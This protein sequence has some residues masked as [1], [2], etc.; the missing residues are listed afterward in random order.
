M[1]FFAGSSGESEVE[2]YT[3]RGYGSTMDSNQGYS[4]NDRLMNVSRSGSVTPVIDEE[5]RS[6]LCHTLMKTVNVS[7]GNLSKLEEI[8]V[9]KLNF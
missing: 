8:K 3:S 9:L 1:A 5:A 7:Q 2:S 6:V 4:Q